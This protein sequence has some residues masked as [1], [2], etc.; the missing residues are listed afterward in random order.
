MVIDGVFDAASVFFGKG[1]IVVKAIGKGKSGIVKGMVA[2]W[3]YT[4]DLVFADP[5][6]FVYATEGYIL[7]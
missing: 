2:H 7:K 3:T 6:T 4:M 1:K 5:N